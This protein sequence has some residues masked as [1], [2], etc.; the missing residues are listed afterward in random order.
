VITDLLARLD[1]Q[2]AFSDDSPQGE[3]D[4]APAARRKRRGSRAARTSEPTKRLTIDVPVSLHW[5]VKMTC[6]QRGTCINS[7]VSRLLARKFVES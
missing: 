7:E 3:G 5:A 6:A 1:R 4:G 2:G